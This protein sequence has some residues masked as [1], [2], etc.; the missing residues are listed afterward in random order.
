[1]FGFSCC[2]ERHGDETKA[3]SPAPLAEE[4]TKRAILPTHRMSGFQGFPFFHTSRLKKLIEVEP[5]EQAALVDSANCWA[6][7]KR[8]TC[9][10]E[11]SDDDVMRMACRSRADAGEAKTKLRASADCKREA[12][13]MLGQ[14]SR[15]RINDQT[16]NDLWYRPREASP[17][18]S[19]SSTPRTAPAEALSC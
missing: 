15:S 13:A 16:R 17:C 9:K 1:M 2:E 14:A 8:P 12:H 4:N 6:S 19:P 5:E 18:C 10:T 7:V 11:I 3:A